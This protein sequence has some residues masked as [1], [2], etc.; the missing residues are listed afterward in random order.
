ML[1]ATDD[2]EGRRRGFRHSGRHVGR[3]R[4]GRTRVGRRGAVERARVRLVHRAEPGH[5]GG[6][7]REPVTDRGHQAG[8]RGQVDEHGVDQA[9]V[10]PR[11]VGI[12][13]RCEV[14]HG[15]IGVGVADGAAGDDRRPG[16]AEGERRTAREEASTDGHG[17]DPI[18]VVR[19]V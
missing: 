1:A 8:D 13:L 2:V 11:C 16:D 7:L 14:G 10:D 19:A 12:G 15:R 6:E 4:V 9:C 17:A 5:R 3:T 18:A